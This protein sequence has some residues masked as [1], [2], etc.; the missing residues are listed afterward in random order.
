MQLR[1]VTLFASLLCRFKKQK[2]QYIFS[3]SKVIMKIFTCTKTEL[4][5]LV[6]SKPFLAIYNNYNGHEIA[7][8]RN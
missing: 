3:F 6:I 7:Q 4:K 2:R 5:Y 1:I 8:E